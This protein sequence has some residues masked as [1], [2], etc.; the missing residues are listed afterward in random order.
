MTSRVSRRFEG[1]GKRFLGICA[2]A[3]L[4]A[5][6][7]SSTTVR[8]ANT[9]GI[10]D[11]LRELQSTLGDALSGYL[12]SG[13]APALPG[14]LTFAAFAC[15]G[16]V[17]DTGQLIYVTQGAAAVG[18]LSGGDGTYWLAI[19]RDQSS[20]V[21]SWTRQ[22]GTHYIWRLSS[23]QP[24]APAGVLVFLQ[25]TVAGGIITAT[26]PVQ[27]PGPLGIPLSKA[28]CDG[29]TDDTATIRA[30]LLRGSLQLPAG[31]CMVGGG[32]FTAL[33]VPGNR[34]VRGQG[35]GVT[36]LKLISSS[37]LTHTAMFEL[38][39]NA[40][41]MQDMT[42]DGNLAGQTDNNNDNFQNL[43][44]G[45]LRSD[46]RL[47][48]LRLTAARRHG[49]RMLDPQRVLI[50]QNRIDNND[51][52]GVIL[53]RFAGTCSN[54]TVI[55]NDMGNNGNAIDDDGA[56]LGVFGDSTNDIY[57]TYVDVVGNTFYSN[58]REGMFL[59]GT[60]YYNVTGNIAHSN[61]A[62]AT[63]AVG[64]LITVESRF[65]TITGNTLFNNRVGINID[66]SDGGN[67]FGQHVVSGNLCDS[68]VESGIRIQGTPDVLVVG[69][70]S[71][72]NGN[73]GILFSDVDRVRAIGN[74]LEG[75]AVYG[76]NAASVNIP[77]TGL[78]IEGNSL[79]ANG[80]GVGDQG[81]VHIATTGVGT[82]PTPVI[83][84]NV[85]S[86]NNPQG[87]SA[88]G[89][90][91]GIT[92][93]QNDFQSTVSFAIG[94]LGS[95]TFNRRVENLGDVLAT[96]PSITD[97]F[98]LDPGGR[99]HIAFTVLA[100]GTRTSSASTAIVDGTMLGQLL[101]M[102]NHDATTSAVIKHN[103][104]TKLNGAVDVTLGPNDTML[105][106]WDGVDWI[107]TGSTGNN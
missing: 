37:S 103:A 62:H 33:L 95:A 22:A 97:G 21:T 31:T 106:M 74:V 88:A 8:A 61:N 13:C 52:F 107:Q 100:G 76:I 81:G 75:N 39:G 57:C 87:F 70:I 49:I 77:F 20:T 2:I 96:I 86:G 23:T 26:T 101:W 18:P 85:F 47:T 58:R 54:I 83:R 72:G 19:H 51:Y 12:V 53:V 71:R 50:S 28:Q 94:S 80:S 46:I 42:L 16:Y 43:I 5:C 34:M 73:Y 36:T 27:T 69:N 25:V 24:A 41:T 38:N 63:V 11:S 59:S 65:G 29:T 15:T 82:M 7:V 9:H 56:G 68:N 64:I 89:S 93:S 90:P 84:G 99:D 91:T 10:P 6:C 98:S 44:Y 40:I 32:A 4:L 45:S 102:K 14:T 30:E 35:I 78:L 66:T 48:N 79:R 3:F 17:V 104:N 67:T 60:R 1:G 55:G 92:I 105:L